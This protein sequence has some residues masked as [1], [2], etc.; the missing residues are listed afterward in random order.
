MISLKIYKHGAYLFIYFV[1]MLPNKVTQAHSRFV[2]GHMS[3]KRV[4]A[5]A[6]LKYVNN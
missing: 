6:P 1:S 3:T 4:H 5:E 2:E